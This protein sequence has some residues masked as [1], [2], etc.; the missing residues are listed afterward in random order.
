SNPQ[1][2]QARSRLGETVRELIYR[3]EVDPAQV[4][5]MAS[6][7]LPARARMLSA[8]VAARHSQ[9]IAYYPYHLLVERTQRI[10]ELNWQLRRAVDDARALQMQASALP[11]STRLTLLST[12]AV[13][14]SPNLWPIA[15]T[16]A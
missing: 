9:P 1:L 3:L 7:S 12:A 13:P 4:Q 10:D 16:N 8:F 2:R 11:T 14:L 5:A 15:I 6:P